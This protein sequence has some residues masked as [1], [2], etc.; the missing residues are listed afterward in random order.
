MVPDNAWDQ[1]RKYSI[2]S[3]KKIKLEK[4]CPEGLLLQ[5][6]QLYPG[7]LARAVQGAEW[8]DILRESVRPNGLGHAV[9]T[10]PTVMRAAQGAGTYGIADDGARHA[11]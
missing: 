3:S 11:F 5:F 6:H 9:I 1:T 2:A 8:R 10:L 7:G 4:R